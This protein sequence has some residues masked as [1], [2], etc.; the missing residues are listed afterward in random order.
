MSSCWKPSVPCYPLV[1]L[2]PLQHFFD[3]AAACN[4]ASR[5]TTQLINPVPGEAFGLGADTHSGT[6]RS[7]PAQPLWAQQVPAPQAP[8]RG[9][10]HRCWSSQR[11]GLH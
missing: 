9:H 2:L 11:P 6:H 3:G 5:A 8:S 7:P 4:L 10:G 1:C